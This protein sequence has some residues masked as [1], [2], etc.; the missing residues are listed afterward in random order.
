MNLKRVIFKGLI[1]LSKFNIKKLAKRIAV[2]SED[3]K[4][5]M[6]LPNA[7]RYHALNDRTINLLMKGNIDMSAMTT[8]DGD[9]GG[10]NSVSD[11][12]AVET[13]H[14]EKEVEMFIVDKN[15]TRAGGCFFPYLNITIFD[16]SKYGI[17]K[18]VDK[19]NY[20]H[21]CLYLAL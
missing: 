11:A 19:T 4:M 13:V 14:K 18:S 20:K 2:L 6:Y 9:G 10:G 7:K 16:L 21:N 8:G 17:F 1:D 15:R 12:E 5:F 3:V